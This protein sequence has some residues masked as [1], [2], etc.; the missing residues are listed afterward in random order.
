MEGLGVNEKN[1]IVFFMLYFRL[2]MIIIRETWVTV[3]KR[4]IE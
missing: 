1:K 3:R 2:F 4:D